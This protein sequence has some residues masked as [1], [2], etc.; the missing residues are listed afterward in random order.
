[1]KYDKLKHLKANRIRIHGPYHAP[2]LYKEDEPKTFVQSIS[3]KVLESH[4]PRIP[5]RSTGTRE[6]FSAANLGHLLEGVLQDVLMR[7]LRWDQV[8]ESVSSKVKDSGHC[9]CSVLR[10][11]PSN[12]GQSLVSAL[13]QDGNFEVSLDDRFVGELEDIGVDESSGRLAHSKIAICGLSGR[14]PDAASPEAF[15]KLLEKGLDLHREVPKDRFNVSTHVD[16]DGKRANTSHTPFGCFIKDPGLFDPRFFG[17]SPR[18]A[19]QTDPMQRLALVT[20]YEAL[21]MSGYVPNRTPSTQLSRIGT[22]YGQTSDDWR[23]IQAAQ[24]VD[25]YFI[26]GGVRAFGPGRI[27]Y[28]FKF[29][30]PSFNIDTAC[31]SSLAAIQLACTSL[32]AGDCDTALAGGMNVLTNPDIFSGLSRGQFLSKKGSCQTFDND[33]DGYCR[34]DGVG[35]VILKR[36]E[37]AK[38]DKDPILAVILGSATNHSAEAV[39][40]THPHAGAQE[41]L[42]KHVLNAA[43]VDPHD[44]SYVEMHGTGTQAGDATE[45]QSVTNVFAPENRRRRPDQQLYLGAVKANAGVFFHLNGFHHLVLKSIRAR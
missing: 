11:G 42:Y 27:N 30:G 21:E 7:T 32:W 34:A 2:H 45:M 14:F 18:E 26:P 3:S 33:A 10:L 40:I 35:T 31:S 6:W 13:R 16:V 22:F 25:T 9:Q 1:M 43:C 36:L 4:I 19:A 38:A 41:F 23:E 44:V 17:I 28:Y 5:I 20:A 12:T 24:K 8:L 37:D 29:S 39:S 15:W